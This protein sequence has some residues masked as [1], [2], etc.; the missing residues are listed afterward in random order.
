MNCVCRGRAAR[1]SSQRRSSADRA[2]ISTTT[3]SAALARRGYPNASALAPRSRPP[4]RPRG[5]RPAHRSTKMEST[6]KDPC[7]AA[8]RDR[9]RFPNAPAA[10]QNFGRANPA[11]HRTTN[12]K[13]GSPRENSSASRRWRISGSN[14]AVSRRTAPRAY[15]E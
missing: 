10:R 15:R 14:A 6:A 13:D 11:S 3:L 4:G 5:Y 7:A 9:T 2:S 12:H 1:T 8:A